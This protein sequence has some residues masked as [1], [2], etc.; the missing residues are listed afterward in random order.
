MH[1]AGVFGGRGRGRQPV[2]GVAR[3]GTQGIV[4]DFK[5]T[6][7]LGGGAFQKDIIEP[8]T[9]GELRFRAGFM[10]QVFVADDGGK[11]T[12]AGVE[13]GNGVLERDAVLFEFVEF[14]GKEFT[15]GRDVRVEIEVTGQQDH[16]FGVV[17]TDDKGDELLELRALNFQAARG[18]QVEEM[19]SA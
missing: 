15:F 13:C 6:G 4:Q 2:G 10:E 18:G 9:G 5:R 17:V 3:E 19:K 16:I 1:D 11:G 8:G 14:S 7:M 12:V